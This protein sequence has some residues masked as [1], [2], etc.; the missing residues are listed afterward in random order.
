[1]DQ[2]NGY[3]TLAPL[4]EDDTNLLE[5]AEEETYPSNDAGV[6]ARRGFRY[7][8]LCAL[9]YGIHSSTAGLWSEVHC[10]NDEDITL[11]RV[12]NDV[13]VRIRYVQVKYKEDAASHWTCYAIC[14][15]KTPKLGKESSVLA[16]LFNKP[17]STAEYDF[18]LATNEGVSDELSS[19]RYRWTQVEP[20]SNILS[21]ASDAIKR[22]IGDW[23]HPEGVDIDQLISKFAIEKHCDTIEDF[24]C[25]LHVELSAMLKANGVELLQDELSEVFTLLH[26][27]VQYAAEA[28][29]KVDRYVYKISVDDLRRKA[30]EDARRRIE[31]SSAGAESKPLTAITDQLYSAGLSAS[32]VE[33]CKQAYTQ[34]NAFYRRHRGTAVGEGV[35]TL[36]DRVRALIMEKTI[37]ESFKGGVGHDPKHLFE[38]IY[39]ELK[40]LSQERWCRDNSITS[41]HV[42]G[43]AMSL[44]HR[45]SWSLNH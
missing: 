25:I 40:M 4:V 2:V 3:D 18:R 35:D 39:A 11:V 12:E 38:L 21:Q 9:R 29:R 27:K 16:K 14:R 31:F 22:S 7:Q 20:S 6:K 37:E 19:S 30:V 15:S 8:D 24:V 36:R 43:I 45:N 44:L 1:M 42:L 33:N 28:D 34:Y 10:E 17:V 41:A 26:H 5:D 13:V 32:V 23:T